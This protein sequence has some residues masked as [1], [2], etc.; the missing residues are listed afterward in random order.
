[1]KKYIEVG[2]DRELS[3]WGLYEEVFQDM[4]E[5]YIADVNYDSEEKLELTKGEV[6]EVANKLLYKS[7]YLWEIIDEHVTTYIDDVLKDR[8]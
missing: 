3:T 7:E 1:M 5:S 6:R 4:V 2:T 8:C